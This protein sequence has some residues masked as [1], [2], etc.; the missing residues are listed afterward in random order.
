MRAQLGRTPLQCASDD[1]TRA[2]LATAPSARASQR[3]AEA[4]QLRANA[5]ASAA[6]S[7]SS[8]A[9]SAAPEWDVFLSFRDAETGDGGD[10]AAFAL[11]AALTAA[12]LRVCLGAE[13]AHQNAPAAASSSSLRR[14]AACLL[15]CSRMYA[16]AALSPAT[17][18]ELALACDL[19]KPRLLIW[20]SGPHFPPTAV[21]KALLL[22]NDAAAAAAAEPLQRI[23]A[24]G[25]LRSGYADAGVRHAAVAEEVLDELARLGI[26]AIVRS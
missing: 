11:H 10:G 3:T 20:H 16:D 7:G 17:A 2:L 18:R 24:A 19:K 26:V 13:S 9:S 14:S 15:L 1:A 8:D 22:R 4:A 6:A 12:G 5:A 21:A 23:P 25:D